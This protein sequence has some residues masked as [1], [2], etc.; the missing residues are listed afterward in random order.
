MYINDLPNEVR[1]A[2]GAN[3]MNIAD[4]EPI[5]LVADDVMCLVKDTESLQAALDACDRWARANRLA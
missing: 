5:R 2:L 4:L 1:D 3:D